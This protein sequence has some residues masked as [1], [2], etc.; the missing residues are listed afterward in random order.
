M[1]LFKDLFTQ[2][3]NRTYSYLRMIVIPLCLAIFL[4][5]LIEANDSIFEI[6]KAISLF[7]FGTSVVVFFGTLIEDGAIGELIG[8]F[9]NDNKS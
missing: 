2:S 1:K 8:R 9:K 4:Y 3:N 6:A 5:K 7:F